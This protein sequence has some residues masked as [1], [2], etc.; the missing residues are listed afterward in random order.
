[1]PARLAYPEIIPA[2]FHSD[3]LYRS[4]Q[5]LVAKLLDRITRYPDYLNLRQALSKAMGKFAWEHVIGQ[6]DRELESLAQISR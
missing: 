1:L 5:D 4:R 3:V 6:Y 2:R